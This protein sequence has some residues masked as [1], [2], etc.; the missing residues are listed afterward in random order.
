MLKEVKIIGIEELDN[1]RFI[2]AQKI[3]AERDGKEFPWEMAK[4]FNS[5]HVFVNNVETKEVMYVKQVRVPV[6]V[7][8]PRTKGHVVECCAGLVDK[9]LEMYQI[10]HEEIVEEM[11]Y[12]IP[13]QNI[14]F[15]RELKSSVGSSG[16]TTYCFYAEVSEKYKVSEGGGLEDEDIEVIRVP[17]AQMFDFLEGVNTD[18]ST[19]FLSTWFAMNIQKQYI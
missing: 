13:Y 19:M 8:D 1:P 18:S 9:E 12:D 3:V 7:N 10:A 17:Y 11:G 2:K 6:L 15:I 16:N 14:R 4:G 5:V